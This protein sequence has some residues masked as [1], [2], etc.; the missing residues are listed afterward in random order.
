VVTPDSEDNSLLPEELK[1][2]I[3]RDELLL[4]YQPELSLTTLETERVEALVRWKHPHQKFLLPGK[5]LPWIETSPQM[6]PL[7]FWTIREGAQQLGKWQE[8]WPGLGMSINLSPRVLA[9]DNLRKEMKQILEVANVNA[10]KISLE[11]KADI[12][13]DESIQKMLEGLKEDG[14]RIVIDDF[15][16]GNSAASLLNKLQAD[17]IKLDKWL[18]VNIL[19]DAQ[20]SVL[21]EPLIH[22]AHDIGCKVIAKGIETQEACLLMQ[23]L[24]CDSAQGYFLGKPMSA[25]DF[26]KWKEVN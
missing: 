23:S 3:E 26:E 12:M 22:M 11:I 10:S 9:V 19:A 21:V 15:S 18:M 2:A 20:D 4:Y 16:V 6:I 5:F 7:S 1:Q 24:G 14:I 8:S 25:S 17:A 13:V